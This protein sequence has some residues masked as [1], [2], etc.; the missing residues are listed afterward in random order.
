MVPTPTTMTSNSEALSGM[1]GA[2]GRMDVVDPALTWELRG[3]RVRS[4]LSRQVYSVVSLQI[5]LFDALQLGT[6]N[7]VRKMSEFVE[8]LKLASV[9]DSDAMAEE[10]GC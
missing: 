8:C 1:L 2:S 5:P 4:W 3:R 6:L 9:R 7:H 10:L